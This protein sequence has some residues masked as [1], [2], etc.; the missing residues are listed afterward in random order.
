MAVTGTQ[1]NLDICTQALRKIG[2]VAQDEQ[3]TA[4]EIET[5]RV[6][7][8]RMLKAWQ[9]KQI[10]RPM[11]AS[12][13]VTLTT[14]ASY[15]LDP[16]RPVEIQSCRLKR[17]GIETPMQELSREEYDSLPI[18]TSAGLPTC[19][20]YDRQ[21]EAAKLYVWPVLA[22]ASGETLEITYV[23]EFEDVA[24]SAVADIPGEMEDA[25]VYN[26]ADRLQ[27]DFSTN[28][29]KVTMMAKELLAEALA[30]DR[31]GSVFF[32]GQEYD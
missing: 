17:S 16:V 22:S 10:L 20:Y 1:T 13:S 23:R 32:G 15:T 30:F 11:T 9:N 26:L 24:L 21:R 27:D 3:A 31:E 12:Q 14:A 4:D 19:W 28:K 7:L 29:P 6:G 2:V 18:K 25:A 5:A 8:R